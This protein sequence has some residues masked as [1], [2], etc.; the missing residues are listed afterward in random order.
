MCKQL[1]VNEIFGIINDHHH[2]RLGHE[3]TCRLGHDT[4]VRVHQVPDGLHLPLQLRVHTAR[5]R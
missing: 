4:H 3:I 5:S 1:P 2:D